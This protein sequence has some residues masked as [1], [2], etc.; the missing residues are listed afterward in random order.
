MRIRTVTGGVRAWLLVWLL[1]PG[2]ALAEALVLIPG[3][4]GAAD[5]WRSH[6]VARHCGNSC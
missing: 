4:L 2:P 5:M 3:Y 6:G 1:L